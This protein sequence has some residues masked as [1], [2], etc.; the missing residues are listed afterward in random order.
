[1]LDRI[2]RRPQVRKHPEA[3]TLGNRRCHFV[4][5]DQ[6]GGSVPGELCR[7]G[8]C[9]FSGTAPPVEHQL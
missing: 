7:K 5:F 9:Y 3:E 2:D 1:M 6:D 8:D 4:K